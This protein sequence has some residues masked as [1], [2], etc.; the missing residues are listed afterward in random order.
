VSVL[1]HYFIN[2]NLDDLEVLEEELEARNVETSQIH[3]LS[4]DDRG[5][6][7]HVHIHDV[8]SLMKRDVI[9]SGEMCWCWPA[10]TSSN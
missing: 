5:T 7:S 9:H 1:R 3:V 4:L 8:T 10:H 2:D 6:E